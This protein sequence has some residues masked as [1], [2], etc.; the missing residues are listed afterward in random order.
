MRTSPLFSNIESGAAYYDAEKATYKGICIKTFIL[1]GITIL[2]SAAVYYYLP[3]II[4]NGRL[5][6]FSAVLIVS[7]IVG[8]IAVLVGRLSE[9]AA[10][11]ASF[12]YAIAE[13]LVIGAISLIADIYVQG[14]V[15]IAL[16][17]TLIV[18]SAMLILFSTGIIR[19]G[20]K[21]RSFM[22]A[23]LLSF[24]PIMIITII[25]SIYIADVKTYL[26]LMIFIEFIYLIYGIFCLLLNF[27]EAQMV[28]DAGCSKKAE[29]SVSLGLMVSLVYIYL[30]IL[31]LVMYIASFSRE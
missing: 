20:T 17:G 5:G 23:F 1:L 29:W 27:K 25:A 11:V 13:G 14:V 12:V 9:R 2:I 4:A 28:V 19:V 8:L 18:F 26:G 22:F 21:F 6:A 3:Q 10:K 30:E 7:L 15:A 24:I 31:R 16:A